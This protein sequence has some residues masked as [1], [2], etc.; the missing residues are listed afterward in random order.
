MVKRV[1]SP[2]APTAWRV[3]LSARTDTLRVPLADYYSYE[4]C[5]EVARLPNVLSPTVL[6]SYTCVL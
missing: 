5:E 2:E 6:R 3:V 1:P 4:V